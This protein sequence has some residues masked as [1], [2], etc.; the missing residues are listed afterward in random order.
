MAEDLLKFDDLEKIDPNPDVSAEGTVP[1]AYPGCV[2][3]DARHKGSR[4]GLQDDDNVNWKL[5]DHSSNIGKL[6]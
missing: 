2:K 6:R 1:H 4:I 3:E 5:A